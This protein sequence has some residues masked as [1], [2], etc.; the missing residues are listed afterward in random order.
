MRAV[1]VFSSKTVHKK[2]PFLVT[3]HFVVPP[4]LVPRHV[5][6]I[7]ISALSR[8]VS[9]SVVSRPQ[10]RSESNRCSLLPSRLHLCIAA[11]IALASLSSSCGQI[12]QNYRPS[13]SFSPCQRGTSARR[14][15]RAEI[16]ARGVA[17]DERWRENGHGVRLSEDEMWTRVP[18]WRMGADCGVRGK[19]AEKLNSRDKAVVICSLQSNNKTLI[20]FPTLLFVL[21]PFSLSALFQ[22]SCQPSLR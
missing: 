9:V 14:G 7:L 1:S 16:G 20:V 2:K 5:W 6:F 15:E 8:K 21:V 22:Y 3:S 13:I 19:E 11:V 10:T 12:V 17:A 4:L 18:R